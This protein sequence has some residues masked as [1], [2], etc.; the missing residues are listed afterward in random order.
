VIDVPPFVETGEMEKVLADCRAN[1]Q[2]RV[3]VQKRFEDHSELVS[4]YGSVTP[5]QPQH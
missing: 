3:C 5:S 2:R 4:Q 1:D